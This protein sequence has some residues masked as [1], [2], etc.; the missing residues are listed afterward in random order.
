M[1]VNVRI[2]VNETSSAIREAAMNP[3]LNPPVYNAQDPRRQITCPRST[4]RH[5]TANINTISAQ[6]GLAALT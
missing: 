4:A 2:A 3:L 6:S 5:W 1:V